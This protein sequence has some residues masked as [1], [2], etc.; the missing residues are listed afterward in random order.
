MARSHWREAAEW[1]D[2]WMQCD[3]LS[4]DAARCAIES[5][6]LMGERGAALACYNEYR[7]RLPREYW[8]GPKCRPSDRRAASGGGGG[9]STG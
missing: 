5:R 6:F 9:R 3:P 2:R 8:H 1:A 7:E 4:E